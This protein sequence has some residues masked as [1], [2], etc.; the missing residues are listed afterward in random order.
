MIRAINWK[1]SVTSD[2]NL[3]YEF[4]LIKIFD[5]EEL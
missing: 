2:R 5:R 1:T 4:S 3:F